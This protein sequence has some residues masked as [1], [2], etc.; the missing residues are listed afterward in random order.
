MPRTCVVVVLED[1]RTLVR[2][3]KAACLALDGTDQ[4]C[5]TAP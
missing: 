2:E 3:L 5:Q 1:W 4:A